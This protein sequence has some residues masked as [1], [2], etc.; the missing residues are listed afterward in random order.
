MTKR[1]FSKLIVAGVGC[2]IST[3]VGLPAILAA[4]APSLK[5]REGEN[6]VPV[7]NVAT[8]P[9]GEVVKAVVPVPR[10]DW[11]AALRERGVFVLREAADTIVVFS[12]NCTDLSCPITWDPGS[13]WFFCPCHGGIFSKEGEPKSGPPKLPLY[14]YA[15]RLRGDMLEIDLNSVPPMI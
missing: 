14:R 1:S 15:T 3:V 12:R 6:W 13:H 8:Y 10:N 9:L 5:R 11:A 4:L 2:V 7:G